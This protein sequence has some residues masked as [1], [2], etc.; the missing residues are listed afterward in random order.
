MSIII[1]WE[2]TPTNIVK[3]VIPLFITW[4]ESDVNNCQLAQIQELSQARHSAVG[5]LIK[6]HQMENVFP[7]A[8]SPNMELSLTHGDP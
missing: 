7:N 3:V 8:E 2:L 5:I 1:L 6:K 4:K